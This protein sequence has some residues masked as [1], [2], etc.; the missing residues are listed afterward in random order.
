MRN[1]KRFGL[2]KFGE[3]DADHSFLVSEDR[4]H[5]NGSKLHQRKF[6]INIR[7][8]FSTERMIK[9]WRRLP[10]EVV[11][12]SSL[13]VPSTACSDFW[14]AMNR[15]GGFSTGQIASTSAPTR[16]SYSF[17]AVR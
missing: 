17:L 8:H 3:G 9:R 6:R 2:V 4:T 14:S 7:K 1:S 16:I 11:D 10:R 5:G 15:C 13:S 12:A